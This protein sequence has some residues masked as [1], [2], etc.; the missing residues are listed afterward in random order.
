[1]KIC[2]P[3]CGVY[4]FAQALRLPIIELIPINVTPEHALLQYTLSTAFSVISS[5]LR[6]LDIFRPEITSGIISTEFSATFPIAYSAH[7]EAFALPPMKILRIQ[8]P[9]LS[10]R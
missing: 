3:A 10:I 6:F 7:F 5:P 4:V 1:M 2:G 9:D 8:A